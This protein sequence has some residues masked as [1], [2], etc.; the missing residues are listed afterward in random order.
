MQRDIK[1]LTDD[2]LKGYLQQWGQPAYRLPQ[3]LQW[4]YERRVTTWAAMT[5]LP[6]ALREVLA[7]NF[8]HHTLELI[9]KQGFRE[10]LACAKIFAKVMKRG[11]MKFGHLFSRT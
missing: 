8:T 9:R 6:K 11:V 3:I 7:E 1:S 10:V 2:E 4:L 5:N